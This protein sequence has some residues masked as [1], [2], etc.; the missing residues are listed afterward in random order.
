MTTTMTLADLAANSL[1]ASTHSRTTRPG[2][3]LRR[4]ATV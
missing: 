3:L 4:K 2:L 1:S